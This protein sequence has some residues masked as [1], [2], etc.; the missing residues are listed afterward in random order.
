MAPIV[1]LPVVGKVHAPRTG[2][3]PSQ[4]AGV[5]LVPREGEVGIRREP[6]GRESAA[7]VGVWA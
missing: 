6:L 3:E 1:L 7:G 4:V 5:V 2:M